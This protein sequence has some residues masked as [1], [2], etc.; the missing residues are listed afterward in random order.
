VFNYK[1]KGNGK[2]I[3]KTISISNFSKIDINTKVDV[4]FSQAPNTGSLDFTVDDNLLDYYDIYT[5]DSVLYIKIIDE[6]MENGINL[7]LYPKKCLI[8]VSSE[9]LE[10]IKIRGSSTINFNTAF[11]SKILN[12]EL[13]GSGKVLASKYPVKIEDVKI[14]KTGSGK[15]E[16]AGTIQQADIQMNGSG[17][18]KFSGTIRKADIQ[19]RGSGKLQLAGT[20]Q[21]S[22][23][24]L[25]GS[26]SIIALDCKI[27]QMKIDVSGSGSAEV[28]VTDTLD[29]NLR[30]S[31]SVRFKGDPYL[32]TK[33]IAG[34][35][36]I[37]KL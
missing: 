19:I 16:L 35:G 14:V 17:T 1:I 22:D 5:K 18:T 21:Q 26:G 34:S 36:K 8:T 30:G 9:Q 2:L 12:I 23:I 6:Y 28:Y 10:N 29:I 27:A 32:F 11:T 33:N 31:G 24:Q 37:K 3:T 7:D 4:N 25:R 13:K 20:I 15:V